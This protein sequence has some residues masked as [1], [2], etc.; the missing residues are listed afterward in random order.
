M[1]FLLTFACLLNT[2]LFYINEPVVD[3]RESP[4][5]TS[6]IVSQAIFSEKINVEEESETWSLITSSDGYSG[7][8]PSLSFVQLDTPYETSLQVCRLAAHVYGVKGTE[9]GPIKILPY[10]SQIQALDETDARWITLRLPDGREAY[11]QKGDVSLKQKLLHKCDLVEFG[12]KFK[13]LPYGWGGRSSFAYDCSGYI[14][15]LYDQIGIQLARDSNQQILDDRFQDI[16]L[17]EIEEGDLIFFG[18]S[19]QKIRHVAMYLGDNEII[20]ATVR[21]NQPWLRISN[22]HDFEW[23]GHQEAYYPYRQARQLIA[24]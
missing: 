2:S 3:M 13:N 7:W 22:L 12:K 24:K 10:G 6:K 20:H 8:V 17:D 23:S 1:A 5:Y 18:L 19:K 14:Q 21:E 9:F 16:T 11:I 15:M 4:T